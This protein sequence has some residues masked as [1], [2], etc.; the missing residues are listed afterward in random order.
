MTQQQI[1]YF[2]EVNHTLFPENKRKV[3]EHELLSVENG[4]SVFN[5]KFKSPTIAIVL[6]LFFSGLGIDRFY[7]G[8]TMLGCIKSGLFALCIIFHFL[9]PVI[10][11]VVLF[12]LAE[13]FL[14][15]EATR[16]K[17]YDKLMYLVRLGKLQLNP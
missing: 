4:L 17:N 7:I 6:T 11:I 13:L 9:S 5:Q 12:N 16:E 1:D 14:I 15:R 10:V 2:L 8:D 3:I